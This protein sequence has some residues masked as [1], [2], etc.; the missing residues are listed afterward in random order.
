MNLHLPGNIPAHTDPPTWP[1][2]YKGGRIFYTSLG[3]PQDFANEHFRR[4]L[5]NAVFWTTKRDPVL[6]T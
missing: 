6:M 4:M 3:H 2:L 1:R 5:V